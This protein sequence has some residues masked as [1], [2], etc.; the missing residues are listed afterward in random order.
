MKKLVLVLFATVLSGFHAIA[1]DKTTAVQNL[2][3]SSMVGL[4]DNSRV[5]Y[6]DGMTY[7]QFVNTVSTSK[8]LSK[9]ENAVAAEVYGFLASK[10]NTGNIFNKYDG[11]SLKNLALAK[12]S[13][14]PV[15]VAKECGWGCWLQALVE[16][17]KIIIEI[18]NP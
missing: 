16:V 13:S 4:V 1:Q 14:G 6:K 18:V 2:L 7:N 5:Y 8:T 10:A 17:I 9:E 15:V 11:K 3:K 12:P